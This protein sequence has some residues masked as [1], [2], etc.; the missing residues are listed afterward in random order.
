MFAVIRL[1]AVIVLAIIVGAASVHFGFFPGKSLSNAFIGFEALKKQ[2][3]SQGNEFNA[4]TVHYAGSLR[5]V[6][7]WDQ[8]QALEGYTVVPVGT[9]DTVDLINM[10]GETVHSWTANYY[11]IWDDSGDVQN[12]VP[13]R[14]IYTRKAKVYPDGRL[15]EAGGII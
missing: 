12:P 7:I 4:G 11:D 13:E 9:G 10:A 3:D 14:F 6:S 15:Q 1:F 8:D 5:G 2:L